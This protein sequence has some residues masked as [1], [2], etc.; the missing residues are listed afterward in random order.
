MYHFLYNFL[1]FFSENQIRYV[2]IGSS[3]YQKHPRHEHKHTSH[4]PVPTQNIHTACYHQSSSLLLLLKKSSKCLIPCRYTMLCTSSAPFVWNYK[5][6]I[7]MLSMC[8]CYTLPN[9]VVYI[10]RNYWR[11]SLVSNMLRMPLVTWS[12]N[13]KYYNANIC[14]FGKYLHYFIK[15]TNVHSLYR[16]IYVWRHVYLVAV[17]LLIKTEIVNWWIYTGKDAFD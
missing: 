6:Y 5:R 8:G 13:G 15:H 10:F 9:W 17:T 14:I 12:V 16:N 2:A 4:T 7:L 11:D 1:F 3:S